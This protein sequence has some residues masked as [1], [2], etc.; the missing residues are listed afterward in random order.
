M[1]KKKKGKIVMPLIGAVAAIAG[2]CFLKHKIKYG[3]KMK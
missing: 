3:G 2:I 1:V